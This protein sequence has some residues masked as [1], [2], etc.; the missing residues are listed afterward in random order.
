MTEWKFF[1]NFFPSYKG[2][3]IAW[4]EIYRVVS[5]YGFAGFLYL[6]M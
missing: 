4:E 1:Q 3:F 6:H 2:Q 5:P